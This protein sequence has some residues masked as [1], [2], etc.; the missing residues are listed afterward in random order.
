MILLGEINN[1][2]GYI[3]YYRKYNLISYIYWCVGESNNQ[4]YIYDDSNFSID[5]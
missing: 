2:V 3:T 4:K 5:C 1:I